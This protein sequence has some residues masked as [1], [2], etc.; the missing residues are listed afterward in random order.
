M[1]ETAATSAPGASL[2][3]EGTSVITT[4]HFAIIGVL[5]VLALLA[6]VYGMRQKR[7]R[8]QADEAVVEHNR[9]VDTTTE[10]ATVAALPPVEPAVEPAAAPVVDSTPAPVP[11][12]DEPIA[13]AA[14]LAASPASEAATAPAG[15]TS[16]ADAPVT[17]LK[18]LGPKVAARLGESGITTVRHL[19]ALDD[20]EAARLDAQLGSFS[21]RMSRDR[22]LEQAR[23]L[24]AGDKA[25]FEAV[26]GRL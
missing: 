21:G 25:G 15:A 1:N 12:D 19:A 20:D 24:A 17:M 11:L 2:I 26:F 8:R 23:F 5:A 16:Y 9:Q 10:P 13:A 4:M 6:I 22:W 7:R 18:G 14:P 3:P